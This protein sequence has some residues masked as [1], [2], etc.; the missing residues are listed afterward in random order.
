MMSRASQILLLIFVSS[1]SAMLC[2]A[3]E[4]ARASSSK[5]LPP[6]F[7]PPA[8]EPPL[9][10]AKRVG[11]AEVYFY[12]ATEDRKEFTLVKT[13]ATIYARKQGAVTLEQLTMSVTYR[14]PGQKVAE[15]GRTYLSFS[16]Y[17][18]R[19]PKPVFESASEIRLTITADGQ[20]VGD[21]TMWRDGSPDWSIRNSTEAARA[22]LDYLLFADVA[23]AKQVLMQVGPLEINLGDSGLEAF[24][25]IQKAIEK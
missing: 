16:L 5:S 15:G 10:P 21:G 22:T 2:H 9:P 12:E 4:T 17:R 13:S 7:V 18:A 11:A 20:V 23:A 24:R 6:V 1:A 19:A 14:V 25:S 3:Q 8:A